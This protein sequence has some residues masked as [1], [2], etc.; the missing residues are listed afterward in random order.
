MINRTINPNNDLK[1]NTT[2][3][4]RSNLL[5]KFHKMDNGNNFLKCLF[6]LYSIEMIKL[7]VYMGEQQEIKISKVR[8][9]QTIELW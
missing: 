3:I 8:R 9:D 4:D 2:N 6:W 7:R 5:P 1:L